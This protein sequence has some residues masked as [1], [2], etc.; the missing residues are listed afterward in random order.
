MR[1]ESSLDPSVS[2]ST[3]PRTACGIAAQRDAISHATT[4]TASSTCCDGGS[5]TLPLRVAVVRNRSDQG[6]I[7][8]FGRKCPESYG[9][10]AVQ[11]V[12]DSLRAGGYEAMAF[13]GDMT[14]PERLRA[15]I[16]SADERG[17][18]NGLVFNMG[19]GI[20]GDSRY[21]HVPA[22]LEMSGVPYTGA[23]PLGHA[24]SLDKVITKILIIDAG[25]PTPR[26]A[27][28]RTPNDTVGDLRYPLIVKPR[29]ESTSFGLQV[30]R[31]E[32]ALREAVAAIITQYRQDALVEEFIDGSEFCVALLGN[33]PVE[34]LPIVEMDFGGRELNALTWAD[35]FHKTSDE[36]TRV[37]P[38]RIDDS[39]ASRLRE[40][41][42]RT[43]RACHCRDYARVDFRVD[44]DGNPYVLEINSM[45]SLG[46]GGSYVLAAKTAGYR[47]DQ[48]VCRIVDLAHKRYFG[49]DVP[50]ALRTATNDGRPREDDDGEGTPSAT[51]S[52]PSS[53]TEAVEPVHRAAPV[54][55][56]VAL[57]APT[58]R[59]KFKAITRSNIAA[60]PQWEKVDPDL[61]RALEVVSLVLP[62][63]SNEYVAGQ[64]IDWDN[65][66]NDPIFQLTFSQQ[67]MLDPADFAQVREGLDHGM[68]AKELEPTIAAIRRKLNPHPGGQSTHNVPML[69]GRPLEGLQH[70][71][72]ETVLFFPS[73]GQTCHAYCSFC[74]RWAQFVETDDVKFAASETSD[75]VEYVRRH[76]GVTDILFTGG[77]PMIMSTA[78]LKRYVE[79]LLEVESVR[80]IRIGTKAPLYWPQRFVTDADADELMRLF[81]RIVGSGKH[82]AIMTHLS[83]P[84]ELSTD[85]AK[86][87]FQRIR[88]TGAN[89][90]LQSPVIRHVNDDPDVWA[91][92][93]TE[94]VRMGAM[95]YYMFVE[96]D[97]GAKRYFELP[98]VRC[99]EIFRDAYQQV[100]GTARTARG[101]VMSAFPGKCHFLGVV[102]IEGKKAFALEYLQ[103]RRHDL[104]RRPFFAAYDPHAT[105]YDQL[106]PLRAADAGFFPALESLGTPLTVSAAASAETQPVAEVFGTI[107]S[108][109]PATHLSRTAGG[110]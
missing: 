48:L 43:F 54:A 86:R 56:P 15:F 4:D 82:L 21:T 59:V 32:Q 66:P 99:W 106:R 84:V 17:R 89:M 49:E 68:T 51:P 65:I 46:G 9:K 97:T 36:P 7:R 30:V 72:R 16:G 98:L 24:V 58:E 2:G 1:N 71:Y 95:P 63:R 18:P 29:H 38:A 67:G 8:A 53:A 109:V 94:G 77:D 57:G 13:E 108:L 81:E 27:V 61:R 60:L 52:T 6:V 102:E 11:S 20:Q 31:S 110:V 23:D 47:F 87:A 37:C 101:P 45:A 25:V 3:D 5:R 80:T 33:D 28:M 78:T 90:R 70:K 93:W 100:S 22:M 35:K 34:T 55:A 26:Y 69:D 39:L 104:V 19:Y 10:K 79:P 74:F 42:L 40:L 103:A 14:M 62:F 44:R 92:M 73:A 75:L 88:A 50:M 105:W 107:D 83:H 91:R 96:R 76:P 41:A 85:I 12:L 64:L